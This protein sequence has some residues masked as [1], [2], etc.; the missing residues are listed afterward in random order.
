MDSYAKRRLKSN[1]YAGI[2]LN[3]SFHSLVVEAKG[4]GNLSFGET[5]CRSYIAKVRQLRLGQGDAETLRNYFVH[6]QKRSSNFFYVIDMDDEGCMQNVFWQMQDL[7]QHLMSGE[8]AKQFDHLCSDFYEVA[9]IANSHENNVN[10]IV[11]D[12]HVLDSTKKLLPPLQVLEKTDNI[13][14][15]PT[16]L[17][18]ERGAISYNDEPNYQFDLN[19]SV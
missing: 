11:E 9:H 4:Y 6:M 3:K 1:D 19:L 16:G 18:R 14:Q 5:D 8:N 13:Q 17:S 12:V 7:G 10:L 15:D 2:P